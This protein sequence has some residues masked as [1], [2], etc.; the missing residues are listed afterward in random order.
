MTTH[1][2]Q[3]ANRLHNA[4]VCVIPINHP[5]KV[6]TLKYWKPYQERLPTG[7]DLRTWFGPSSYVK[8]LAAVCGHV[9]GGLRMYDFDVAGYY[10]K[11]CELVGDIALYLPTQR[12]G[13]G[14]V[15]VALRC[16]HPG[17]NEKLAWHP[18][19]TA[20]AGRSIAIETRGEGG[21]AILAP[22][23]H[24]TGKRYVMLHG[25]FA[26]IPTVDQCIADE[27]SAAARE[28][29]RAPTTRQQLEQ[30]R[31][32][33]NTPL[34]TQ[35]ATGSAQVDS[36]SVIEAFNVQ[37]TIQAMLQRFG[38]TKVDRR[39]RRWSRPGQPDSGGVQVLPNNKAFF[40]SSNDPLHHECHPRGPFDLFCWYV[41]GGDY[42][43]AVADAAQIL[44]MAK[45]AS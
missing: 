38:Y 42:G 41:H 40:F 28:L 8:A 14:G 6:P 45:G 32:Q 22:S 12:T 1:I 7:Y 18:D 2:Y 15:Q 5:D 33:A 3:A 27:L 10:E 36:G 11:W 19:S 26:Q 23:L 20:D 4:G 31:R 29:C 21:Y 24:S 35:A 43:R 39:V 25:D 13:G 9:S 16:E 17:G 34:R 30:E 37:F 44:G